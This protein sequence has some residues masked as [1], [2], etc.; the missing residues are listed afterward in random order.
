MFVIY[1]F[2]LVKQVLVGVIYIYAYIIII[3]LL[4]LLFD[5]KALFIYLILWKGSWVVLDM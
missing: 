2:T 4:L 5:F 1:L 3:I